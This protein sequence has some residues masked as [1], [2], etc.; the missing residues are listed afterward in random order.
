LESL[1]PPPPEQLQL[2]SAI[3]GNQ[4]AMDSFIQVVSG[5]VSPADFFAPENVGRIFAAAAHQ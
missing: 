4:T 3:H 1:A 5:V 2:M